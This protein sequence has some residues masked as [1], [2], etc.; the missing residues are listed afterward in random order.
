[1]KTLITRLWS[2]KFFVVAGNFLLLVGTNLPAGKLTIAAVVSAVYIAVQGA[3][4]H[5]QAL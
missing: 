3:I 2:K 1:M 4:D 5:K